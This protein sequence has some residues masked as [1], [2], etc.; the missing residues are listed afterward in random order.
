MI[1]GS[2]A[3]ALV[4]IQ[5]IVITLVAELSRRTSADSIGAFGTPNVAHFCSALVI[6]LDHVHLRGQGLFLSSRGARSL[7][8][9]RLPLQYARDSPRQTSDGI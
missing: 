2:A 1:I 8:D 7:R 3:A 6:F 4:G 5:F 9:R